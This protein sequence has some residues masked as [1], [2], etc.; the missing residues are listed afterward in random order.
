MTARG[1]GVVD[2][3][4]PAPGV[5][6]ALDDQERRVGRKGLDSGLIR[7]QLLAGLALC[8]LHRAQRHR[9]RRIAG[10]VCHGRNAPGER[11]P[12]IRAEAGTIRI[13]VTALCAVDARHLSARPPTYGLGCALAPRTRKKPS[14]DDLTGTVHPATAPQHA[15]PLRHPPRRRLPQPTRQCPGGQPR[16]ASYALKL[17]LALIAGPRRRAG[18]E[19]DET[20][21][22]P[23]VN[24]DSAYGDLTA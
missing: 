8:G 23:E 9:R 20:R 7:W 16:Q 19:P 11:C 10:L 3:Q 13:G 22:T 6:P 24:K 18:E 1:R 17:P 2:A 15:I 14:T 12:A 4:E 21:A 5:R